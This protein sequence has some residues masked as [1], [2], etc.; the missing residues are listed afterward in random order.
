MKIGFKTHIALKD[1]HVEAAVTFSG[2]AMIA[3]VKRTVQRALLKTKMACAGRTV[4]LASLTLERFAPS[5]KDMLGR[6]LTEPCTIRFAGGY[7]GM[8]ADQISRHLC[9]IFA[10]L[11]ALQTWVMLG[12]GVTD[13]HTGH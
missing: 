4:Q 7:N 11:Y 6:G 1:S 2:T 3:N 8:S 5:L 13:I 10:N 9:V 12:F